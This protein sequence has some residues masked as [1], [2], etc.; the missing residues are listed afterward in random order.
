[1]TI[2]EIKYTHTAFAVCCVA[3]CCAGMLIIWQFQPELFFT[4]DIVRFILWAHAFCLPWLFCHY[5]A[6]AVILDFKSTSK[7]SHKLFLLASVFTCTGITGVTAL[8]RLL[9]WS[10]INFVWAV[11]GWHLIVCLMGATAEWE[12]RREEKARKRL[13]SE[14]PVSG[15]PAPETPQSDKPHAT[16]P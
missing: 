8:C 15:Q 1:M 10:L 5:V 7:E 6:C 16:T 3:N 11:I 9:N 14:T 12:R 2:S 4:L 13:A